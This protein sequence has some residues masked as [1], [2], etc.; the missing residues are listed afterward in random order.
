M[1]NVR[2]SHLSCWLLWHFYRLHVVGTETGFYHT[3]PTIVYDSSAPYRFDN[4]NANH[5]QVGMAFIRNSQHEEALLAMESAMHFSQGTD[6]VVMREMANIL[7]DTGEFLEASER[8]N[9]AGGFKR[10]SLQGMRTSGYYYLYAEELRQLQI[11]T[12]LSTGPE[13]DSHKKE[14]SFMNSNADHQLAGNSFSSNKKWDLAVRAYRAGTRYSTNDNLPEAF[15]NLAKCKHQMSAENTVGL[16]NPL[17]QHAML[18]LKASL[19]M[20]PIAYAEVIRAYIRQL[21]DEFGDVVKLPEARPTELLGRYSYG[22]RS[23]PHW[24][25]AQAEMRQECSRGWCL[26]C[27]RKA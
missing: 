14:Y 11:G 3:E 16:R 27:H 4:P 13:E 2:I 12:Q 25:H 23:F 20:A 1:S 7:Q 21:E 26:V 22:G 17:L 9:Q 5:T 10:S 18:Y 8:M 6:S 15:F 24:D 19:Q